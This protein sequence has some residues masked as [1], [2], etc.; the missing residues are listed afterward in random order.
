MQSSTPNNGYN[1]E[2]LKKQCEGQWPLIIAI[3]ATHLNKAIEKSTELF[4]HSQ[5]RDRAIILVTDGESHEGDPEAAARLL[6]DAGPGA[7]R[8]L[9]RAGH[10][11]ADLTGIAEPPSQA[12]LEA[13]FPDAASLT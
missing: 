8:G 12:E 13:A 4:E 7:S 11:P 5:R 1:A 6:L 10:S 2:G 3:L 9:Q